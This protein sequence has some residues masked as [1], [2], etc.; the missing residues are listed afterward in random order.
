[1]PLIIGPF[2]VDNQSGGKFNFG[3]VFF[4]ADKNNIHQEGRGSAYNQGCFNNQASIEMNPSIVVNG[5]VTDIIDP[6]IID[7]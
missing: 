2:I 1:M 6:D 4:T 3:T 5:F 7:K